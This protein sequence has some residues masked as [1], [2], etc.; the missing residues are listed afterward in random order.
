[1]VFHFLHAGFCAEKIVK[2]V[3]Q[4]PH[5]ASERKAWRRLTATDKGPSCWK[6]RWLPKRLDQEPP[7]LSW[8]IGPKRSCKDI[9]WKTIYYQFIHLKKQNR[10]SHCKR[11]AQIKQHCKRTARTTIL[12]IWCTTHFTLR[13]NKNK[14]HCETSFESTISKQTFNI[15]DEALLHFHTLAGCKNRH[16]RNGKWRNKICLP[17]CRTPK[18]PTTDWKRDNEFQGGR[19]PERTLHNNY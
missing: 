8:H 17:P 15:H 13:Y 6:R 5:E 9:C 7:Q 19:S 12:G 10:G 4:R 1:M 18:A 11:T 16:Q 2:R 3:Q 14:Q